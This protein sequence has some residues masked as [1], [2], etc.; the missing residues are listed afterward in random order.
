MIVNHPGSECGCVSWRAAVHVNR[1]WRNKCWCVCAILAFLSRGITGSVL[2]QSQVAL[3][4]AS[5][6]RDCQHRGTFRK[7]R[8]L[9]AS[10]Q[11]WRR[12]RSV[13]TLTYLLKKGYSTHTPGWEGARKVSP[14]LLLLLF[15]LPWPFIPCWRK[16]PVGLFVSRLL[17]ERPF[18]GSIHIA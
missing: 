9:F 16:K 1:G 4:S 13:R 10:S 18:L 12:E 3:N 14:S 8:Y 15:R 2:S 6:K 5:F 7:L 17:S 11:Q